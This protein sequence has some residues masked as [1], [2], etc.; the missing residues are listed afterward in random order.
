LEI[1][2][3][4]NKRAKGI[5]LLVAQAW[6][7]PAFGVYYRKVLHA[8]GEGRNR[9]VV[10]NANQGFKKLAVLDR[11]IEEELGVS[12]Q[13]AKAEH[14]FYPNELTSLSITPS[15]HMLFSK[16][17]PREAAV[18]EELQEL[19]VLGY[20]LSKPRNSSEQQRDDTCTALCGHVETLSQTVRRKLAPFLMDL[21]LSINSQHDTAH[22][23]I[24]DELLHE[25]NELKTYLAELEKGKAWLEDQID[26]QRAANQELKEHI[27]NLE[28]GKE[29]LEDQVKEHQ[30]E[31]KN[32]LDLCQGQ[33]DWIG[34]LEEG[35]AWLED[36]VKEHQNEIKN[37]LDLCQ[38]QRD[39]IGQ[40]EE[41]KA[42]LEGQWKSWMAAAENLQNANSTLSQER[43]ALVDKLEQL[44]KRM[45]ELHAR[46]SKRWI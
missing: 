29:W 21:S 18:F 45:D 37:L 5:E 44:H 7:I 23:E 26:S 39:W 41:G 14:K 6:A 17:F 3:S 33:R 13:G 20:D 4:Y 12:F 25:W 1:L 31:I 24:H 10:F 42:W 8:I 9:F 43:D 38:R 46:L 27:G 19:A 35:K 30:N 32:L 16:L 40:L 22:T 36:Q 2:H 11:R 34:R 15:V 28:K